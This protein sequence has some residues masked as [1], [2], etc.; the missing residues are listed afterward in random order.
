MELNERMS[1]LYRAAWPGDEQALGQLTQPDASI[2]ASI[3]DG[4]QAPLHISA[5]LGHVSLVGVL[6][7][8]VRDLAVRVDSSGRTALHLASV[9][10]HMHIVRELLQVNNH[11]CLNCDREGRL[12]LHYAAVRGR[13]EVVQEL[14]MARPGSL[15]HADGREESTVSHLC[16]TCNHLETLEAL[17]KLDYA[18]ANI[19]AG[20]PPTPIFTRPHKAG[21]TLLHLAMLKRVEVVCYLLSIPEIR[22]IENFTNKLGFTAQD[23]V[24]RSPKDFKMGEIQQILTKAEKEGLETGVVPPQNDGCFIKILKCIYKS[25]TD[26]LKHG[27]TW[28]EETRGQLSTVSTFIATMTFQGLINPP[29][30]FIQQGLSPSKDNITSS[31]Q[32]HN[33]TSPDDDPLSCIT[34]PPDNYTYFPGQAL[35][36]SSQLHSEFVRYSFYVT[37]SFFSSLG[38]TLLLVSGIFPMKNRAVI[39]MLSMGV[40]VTLT[41]VAAAYDT[42][43]NIILPGHLLREKLISNVKYAALYKGVPPSGP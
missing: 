7:Y 33:G 8:H 6:L 4:H 37:I 29:G 22:E 36:S 2:L 20:Q 43:I 12:P 32:V 13:T 42:S 19:T 40:C 39:W 18:A 25:L 1:E 23:I 21:N 16:L 24:E 11:P 41:S 14:I 27:D 26:W 35:A 34:I 15:S 3:P 31:N 9:A 38:V 30:S 17:V 10:G 5:L 28:V